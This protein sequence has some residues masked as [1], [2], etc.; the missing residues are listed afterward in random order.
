[1]RDY[2][3]T[4]FPAMAPDYP[5]VVKQALPL[6][7]AALV[8]CDQGR[9]LLLPGR[10]DAGMRIELSLTCVERVLRY[11]E[12]HRVCL[13]VPFH[14]HARCVEVWNSRVSPE[15]Q[16]RPA[17]LFE[18]VCTPAL[19]T[20]SQLCITTVRDIQTQ[21]GLDGQHPFYHAFD[22]LVVQD[23]P[24]RPGPAWTRIV[25]ASRARVLGMSSEVSEEDG[26][27]FFDLVI[28]VVQQQPAEHTT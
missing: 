6:L 14:L 21:V 18:T 20:E 17:G 11:S 25:E 15:D 24:A 4:L 23:V 7:E 26:A 22:V 2:P 13:L 8:S 10:L 1:M 28:P 16:R 12:Y 3:S 5:D 9:L 19:I 27:L